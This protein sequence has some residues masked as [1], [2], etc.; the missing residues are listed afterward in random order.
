MEKKDLGMLGAFIILVS[1]LL[2]GCLGSEDILGAESQVGRISVVNLSIVDEQLSTG[3]PGLMV[4]EL[5]VSG[6]SNVAIT[7]PYNDLV[8]VNLQDPGTGA[9][10]EYTVSGGTISISQTTTDNTIYFIGYGKR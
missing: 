4:Y 2:S 6:T 1:V 7:T 9:D 5:N 10:P 8:Y 3:I